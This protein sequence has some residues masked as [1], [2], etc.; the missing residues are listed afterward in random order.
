MSNIVQL[1]Q[2]IKT[3]A[4]YEKTSPE[5]SATFL[6]LSAANIPQ[7]TQRIRLALSNISGITKN[8]F[9]RHPNGKLSCTVG[10]GYDIWT[11][12]IQQPRPAE[13]RPF[14]EVQGPKYTAVSTPGD[15]L[16]HIRS[17]RR[18]LSF[19]FERQLMDILSDAVTVED[20]TVGFRYFDARD[21]LGFVDGTAN[22]VGPDVSDTVLVTELED[23]T[24]T[25]LG[26]SYVVVQKYLHDLE[27]WRRLS[28]EE[29][30]TII[31]RTKLDN[32]E[33]GDAAP[34]Q[35]KSH[36]SLTTIEDEDGNE[37]E[38]LRDNMPF[39]S[40]ASGEFGTY[41]IGY[42]KKL[43][44]IE[45]MMERMFVG[46][47]PGLHDRIISAALLASVAAGQTLNIPTRSGAI[48]SL[49]AP[50]VI[51]GVKDMGNKEY[52]RGRSCFTDVETPGGHPVFILEDGATLSNAIIGAGQVEGIHCRGAC[53]LK[54]VWFRRVCDGAI[55]LKGNGNVLIEG[56]GAQTAV[57][58]VVS[59]Q[60]QGTVTIKDYTV[61]D[62]NRL[63]RSCGNCANNGGPRNV[64]VQNLKANDL[65]LIAGINSNFGDVST[66]S[67]SCGT[68]VVKVCQEFKGVQKGQESP[69]V[70][71]TANC[72]G[73]VSL[74]AC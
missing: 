24:P 73:Q 63:Y 49:P 39:G 47:P 5:L 3:I 65:T 6:V 51:S 40:P 4:G 71:T 11:Q 13:L 50:S 42:S 55:T 22:P 61:V 66:V 72:K 17:E 59:H 62:S 58:N 12:I 2:L 34:D 23:T 31:G 33:L 9:T 52:D 48:I 20:E 29:Q 56:G 19:E 35:Q 30:E 10:I 28:T 44:V 1:S 45:K 53:T 8:I 16:F 60:G 26:G 18:D 36:K 37:H 69:K 14:T 70:A 74:A 54:N 32:N 38:I 46:N 43:W 67:N 27:S 15:L 41:F 25:A 57:D 21:V 64:V 7:A 68:S